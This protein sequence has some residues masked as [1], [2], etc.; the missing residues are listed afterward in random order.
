[1][2]NREKHFTTYNYN[3]FTSDA[4]DAKTKQK[5]L[6]NKSDICNLW[7]SGINAKH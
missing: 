1:M 4:I 3:T 7:K 5:E 6:V 2:R